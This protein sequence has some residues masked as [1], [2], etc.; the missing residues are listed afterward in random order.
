MSAQESSDRRRP[1]FWGETLSPYAKPD[2]GRALLDVGT[3]AL[4]YLAVTALMYLVAPVSAL[5][6]FALAIP[7]TGFLVRTFIVFHDCSHGSFLPSR[8]ANTWLSVA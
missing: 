5:L 2:V 6:V 4:P 1:A 8:R 3:S 7:A